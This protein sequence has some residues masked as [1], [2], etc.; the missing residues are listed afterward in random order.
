MQFNINRLVTLLSLCPLIFTAGCSGNTDPEEDITKSDPTEPY[1]LIV[2]KT[3]IESDGK[4]A[5]MFTIKDANGLILTDAEH[6]GNT[7]FH[8]AET[9]EWQSGLV[10]SQP[11]IFTT[12]SDG[13]YTISAMY[14]GK[15]CA[16]TVTVTSKN[17][18]KYEKFHKNVALYRLTGT[19]CGYCPSMTEALEKVNTF[20]KDHTV[21][22]VFHNADEFAVPYNSSQ[23][24]AAVLL[25]KFGKSDSGLPYCIYSLNEA[26]GDRK[27]SDIQN[28]VKTQ[29]YDHP[30]KTGIKATSVLENGTLKV[31]AT[32]AASSEGKFDLGMAILKDNCKPSSSTANESVYNNVVVSISGNFFSLSN[33][34]FRLS[35]GQEKTVERSVETDASGCRIVLFTLA[36]SDGKATIDNVVEFKAGEEIEYQYN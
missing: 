12:I 29:L 14:Q 19:W 17:R 20:T 22:L 26:S 31:N 13:T 3:S 11:N 23:D 1:T 21:T 5:A 33:E 15:Y 7:S 2:D 18:S 32:I 35:A 36:D 24:L 28:F 6:L 27:V 8:I 10:L 25:A 30:A 9:D 16:N 34:A 4:D